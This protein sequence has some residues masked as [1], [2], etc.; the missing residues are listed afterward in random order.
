[1]LARYK[2]ERDAELNKWLGE[3]KISNGPVKDHQVSVIACKQI[4][5]SQTYTFVWEES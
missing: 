3:E 2:E 1:M 5:V 4:A